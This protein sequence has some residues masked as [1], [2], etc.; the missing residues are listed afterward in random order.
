MLHSR[1][2]NVINQINEWKNDI[3][4]SK[5]YEDHH[6]DLEILKKYIEEVNDYNTK[7]YKNTESKLHNKADHQIMDEFRK[8][9]EHK[10]MKDLQHKIDK[11][12]HQR[13]QNSM[14][15]KLEA[16]EKEIVE[17]GKVTMI[18][19]KPFKA[20]FLKANDRCISCNHKTDP[21]EGEEP[22]HEENKTNKAKNKFMFKELYLNAQKLGAGY[23][24]I[25]ETIDA[26]DDINILTAEGS[27]S[28][29]DESNFISQDV[30]QNTNH[31]SGTMKSHH[32]RTKT[33]SKNPSMSV[34]PKVNVSDSISILPSIK[35]KI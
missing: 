1:I 27:Y 24:R 7:L 19:A 15:K 6:T 32:K 5:I 3:N 25:L 8:N 11:M 14:R 31:L 17:M 12:E 28:K 21:N 13:I 9:V 18:G 4:I 22:V 35:S 33:M 34:L 26:N 20:P 16:M 29:A 10:V 2:E 23:S 30:T